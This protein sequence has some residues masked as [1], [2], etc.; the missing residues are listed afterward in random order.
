M[1]EIKHP[2]SV[3]DGRK[4]PLKNA[5][6]WVLNYYNPHKNVPEIISTVIDST[7]SKMIMWDKKD[8]NKFDV[9]TNDIN[10]NIK[11]NSHQSCGDLWKFYTHLFYDIIIYDPP[12]INLKNRKDSKKYEDIFNYN[13]MPSIRKLGE[14]TVRSSLS[15]SKL[16]K[17]EGILIAKITDFHFEK[18]IRGH[19]DF[20][21]WFSKYFY[22]WDI[23]IYRFYK[24]IPNLNFYKK[25]CAK[26]H[27]YFLIFRKNKLI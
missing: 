3:I 27:S 15:F 16:L 1:V 11:S 24:P 18:R 10:T 2:L 12:Y 22:L 19:Y 25:R 23:I 17:K 9:T 8:F 5:F 6:S 13:S 26:T 21:R 4:I 14:L 20:I 7:C